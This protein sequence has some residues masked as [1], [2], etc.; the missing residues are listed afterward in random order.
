MDPRVWKLEDRIEKVV[1]YAS[2]FVDLSPIQEFIDDGLIFQTYR[3]RS[4]NRQYGQDR[5]WIEDHPYVHDWPELQ[6]M[7]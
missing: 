1:I 4:R 3:V 2:D 5:E 6:G 7:Q